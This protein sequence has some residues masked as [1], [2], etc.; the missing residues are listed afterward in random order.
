M[1]F[2]FAA[3]FDG[4]SWRAAD[5][6][7]EALIGRTYTDVAAQ[8]SAAWFTASGDTCVRF[9]GSSW[10]AE[11]SSTTNLLAI[12]ARA[13]RLFAAGRDG[14]VLRRDAAGWTTEIAP[15]VP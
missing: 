5:A 3:H 7:E 1:P 15:T 12:D 2:A 8:P 6:P 13:G 10:T 4:T 9:D 11:G 14:K